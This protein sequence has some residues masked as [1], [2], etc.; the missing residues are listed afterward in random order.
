MNLS[1]RSC[2]KLLQNFNKFKV[3]DTEHTGRPKSGVESLSGEIFIQSASRRSTYIINKS[4]SNFTSF[5]IGETASKV[6]K[7][8]SIL[9]VD[10]TH[11]KWC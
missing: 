6:R 2:I 3:E 10:V 1:A 7:L 11:V 8:G 4:A 9:N 5:K